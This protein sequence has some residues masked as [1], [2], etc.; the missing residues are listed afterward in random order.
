MEQQPLSTDDTMQRG[1][2]DN[3]EAQIV[4]HRRRGPC[5][6]SSADA[7]DGVS[8]AGR[9]PRRERVPVLF[10]NVYGL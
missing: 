1:Q 8:G 3:I 4:V 6:E 7:L 9:R 5:S 2:V 10:R